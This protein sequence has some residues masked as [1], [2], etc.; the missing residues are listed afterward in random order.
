MNTRKGGCH[1]DLHKKEKCT[2]PITHSELYMLQR[3]ICYHCLALRE[4]NRQK[5][6]VCLIAIAHGN[7]FSARRD[8]RF[9]PGVPCASM[10]LDLVTCSLANKNNERDS[11]NFFAG[12]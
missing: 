5:G 9:L 3:T 4:I 12:F 6:S 2:W 11:Q 8:T 1:F 7:G 10:A